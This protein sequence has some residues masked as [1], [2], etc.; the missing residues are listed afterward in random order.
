MSKGLMRTCFI[1]NIVV[2]LSL[3]C[4]SGELPSDIVKCTVGDNDCVRDKIMEVF[5]KYPKGNP[6][7]GLPNISALTLNDVTIAQVKGNAPITLNFKFLKMTVYNMEKSIILN[8]TGWSR[9]PKIIE[10]YSFVDFVKIVGDYES[11]GKAL[12]FTLNGKGKG[13][14][15]LS[16]CTTHTKWRLDF[17]QRSDGKKYIKVSK[18]KAVMTPQ[19]MVIKLDNLVKG[20]KELTDSLNSALNE[21][22]MDFWNEL[23]DG[24]GNSITQ[25]FTNVLSSVFNELS[26]DDF[27]ST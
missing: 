22:W 10:T 20:S 23:S 3:E 18:L 27:F 7:F 8:T 21:N 16:N 19:K 6:K 11:E 14:V 4:Q 5:Q 12:L 26:Y 13:V 1:L 15:E 24:I 25:I 9:E 17:E 2:L